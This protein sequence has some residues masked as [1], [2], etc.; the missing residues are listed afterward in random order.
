MNTQAA[1]IHLLLAVSKLVFIYVQ[2]GFIDRGR[3]NCVE[4]ASFWSSAPHAFSA[5][6]L[7]HWHPTTLFLVDPILLPLYYRRK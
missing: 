5:A 6:K 4:G 3:I 2:S 7:P 1:C